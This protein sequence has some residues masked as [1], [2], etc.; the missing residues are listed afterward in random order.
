MKLLPTNDSDVILPAG[1]NYGIDVANK[2][3]DSV[4]VGCGSGLDRI[5]LLA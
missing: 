2:V 1:K 3:A 4:G 5:I